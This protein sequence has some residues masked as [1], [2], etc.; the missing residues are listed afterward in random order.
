M[1]PTIFGQLVIPDA[2]CSY[3][4]EEIVAT[5]TMNDAYCQKKCSLFSVV[6]IL[7]ALL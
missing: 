3:C 5:L 6:Q 1:L 2:M 4:G 7:N